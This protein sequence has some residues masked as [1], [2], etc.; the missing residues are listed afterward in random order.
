VGDQ[1]SETG[2]IVGV[3]GLSLAFQPEP[4]YALDI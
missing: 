2:G 4:E 1:S 3:G